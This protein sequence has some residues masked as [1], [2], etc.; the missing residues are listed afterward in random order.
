VPAYVQHP[1]AKILTKPT[2]LTNAQRHLASA[3]RQSTCKR[4]CSATPLWGSMLY[5]CWAVENNMS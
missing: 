3:Q 1:R 5:Q 4:L 2:V